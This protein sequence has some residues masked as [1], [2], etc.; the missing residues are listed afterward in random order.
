MIERIQTAFICIGLGLLACFGLHGCSR[1]PAVEPGIDMSERFAIASGS[2]D[3]LK[4]HMS[5]VRRGERKDA[6]VLVAPAS[7]RASLP[8]R[9]ER[10][11][12]KCWAAPVFNIGDGIQM[13]VYLR[14]KGTRILAGSRYF[15][16]GR[17]AENR[18]WIP[19]AIPLEI[20]PGDQLDIEAS[21]G[22][23]GDLVADWLALSSPHL[24]SQ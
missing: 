20:D 8:A 2:P 16:P 19:I 3:N 5:I 7:I 12:L 14:R 22:P 13:N 6:L 24:V 15:D 1:A 4:T 17:K 10:R 9:K 21:G 11:I 23:Q 18:N